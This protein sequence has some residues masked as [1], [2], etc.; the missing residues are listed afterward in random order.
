MATSPIGALSPPLREQ[1]KKIAPVA[2]GRTV[3]YP[4]ALRLTNGRFLPRAYL[5]PYSSLEFG[6]DANW[7]HTND[8]AEITPSPDRL[9]AEFANQIRAAGESGFGYYVF[10]VKFSWLWQRS[11]LTSLIDFIKYPFLATPDSVRAVLPHI[12]NG[13]ANAPLRELTLNWC[14][15]DDRQSE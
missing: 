15:F 2:D 8:I 6:P 9:P 10:T 7:I 4:C 5:V 11:Y 1:L 14:A 12:G 13:K 3:R